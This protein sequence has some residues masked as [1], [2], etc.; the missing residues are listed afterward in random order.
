MKTLIF[1]LSMVGLSFSLS[2]AFALEAQPANGY[3]REVGNCTNTTRNTLYKTFY[4]KYVSD[5]ASSRKGYYLYVKYIGD[6]LSPVGGPYSTCNGVCAGTHTQSQ[7]P[8]DRADYT[9]NCPS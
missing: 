2:T 1:A 3:T 8:T 9:L 4:C 7:C 6:L 5:P